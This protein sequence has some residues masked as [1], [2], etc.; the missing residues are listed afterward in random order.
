MERI[1]AA[2]LLTVEPPAP[3]I[4]R[5]DRAE[6]AAVQSELVLARRETGV[7]PAALLARQ[8]A[9][10]QRVRRATW[11]RSSAGTTTGAAIRTGGLVDRLDGRALVSYGRYDDEMF[12]V[13]IG[14]GRRRLVR[15]GPWSTVRFEGDALRFALRRMTTPGSAAALSA[16]WASARRSVDRLTVQ[17]IEPL[18]IPPDRPLV[19][20]PA[21]DTHRLPWSVLH[22]A[23][24]SVAPSAT[25]WAATGS[26]RAVAAGQI[27]VV[28]GPDLPGAE[29]EA[30]VVARCHP[31]PTVLLP[32]TS[33]AE[34]VLDAMAGADLVHLACHGLL[35]DDNP[36]FSALRVGD[37][38]VT[39]HELD[40][41]GIAPHRVVLAACESAADV[42]YDGDELVGFVSALLARGTAGIVAS[43]VAVG[44]TEA[45][46]LMRA[47]HER[48]AAG[49][50]MA[51]A[52]HAAR[53]RVGHD[54]PREFVDWCA[55]TAYGAG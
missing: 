43:V 35:R 55:F 40:L 4:V 17:L 11:Y 24:V 50:P 33:T 32:S 53:S 8:S 3:D 7:E 41:R 15:L 21:R 48:I 27:V 45:V 42:A 6:L 49:D 30:D 1:R 2:A 25:L 36:T 23:P 54:D 13:V 10:E 26:R 18:R 28:A 14:A 52:L 51:E 37:G 31:N 38:V 16:A 29:R 47:L 39:V 20:I 44:D 22:P 9:A 12:A 5:E 19:V 34:Q 46:P